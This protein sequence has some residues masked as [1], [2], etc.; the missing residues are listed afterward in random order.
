MI[1]WQCPR[2]KQNFY[3]AYE[4]PKQQYVTCPYCTYP[5]VENPYYRG[6]EKK[7]A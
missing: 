6:E 2:C 3:S 5:R 7:D 4:S 1:S